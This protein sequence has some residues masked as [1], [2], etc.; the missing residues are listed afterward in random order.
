MTT[1]DV[2]LEAGVGG[3]AM[4]DQ[5]DGDC[6][7]AGAVTGTRGRFLLAQHMDP[8]SLAIQRQVHGTHVRTV[9]LATPGLGATSPQDA[10]GD[11]DGLIT[12]VVG[13]PLAVTVA[14]CVPIL[15]FEPH[16]GVVAALHAGREGTVGGIAT[17]GIR[18]MVSVFGADPGA[19]LAVIGPSA[20]PCCY[21]VSPEMR[22]E[23]GEQGVV[24]RG[25]HLDLWQSNR[26]Q[27]LGGGVKDAHIT[28]TKECT[29]CTERYYSYRRQGTAAR[30][31]A[32][33]MR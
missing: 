9:G 15:L 30:N 3:A 31:L 27:L 16:A 4:S 11:G 8:P 32:A 20:G 28:V 26:A 1:F 7:W 19:I 12:N 17:E 21:E 22:D 13:L 6:G 18:Q 14:D 2:L 23:C 29:I 25:R 24:T 5:S 10:M 33:I